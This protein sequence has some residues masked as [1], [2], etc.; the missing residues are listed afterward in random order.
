VGPAG[1]RDNKLVAEFGERHLA[2]ESRCRTR[3]SFGEEADGA[4]GSELAGVGGPAG[5]THRATGLREE[6]VPRA[7]RLTIQFFRCAFYCLS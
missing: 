2:R 3:P 4:G 5:V 1:P 6:G 7:Q